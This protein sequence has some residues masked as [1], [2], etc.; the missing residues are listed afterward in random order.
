MKWSR[1]SKI[2]VVKER[3][4]TL[5]GSGRHYAIDLASRLDLPRLLDDIVAK[6][7]NGSSAA[8]AFHCKG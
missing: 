5:N 8:P 6:E 1:L 2:K 3:E 7:E 4:P